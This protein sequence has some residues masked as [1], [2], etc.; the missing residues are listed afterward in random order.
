[1]DKIAPYRKPLKRAVRKKGN[2][3]LKQYKH[4]SQI[5]QAINEQSKDYEIGNLQEL[6]LMMGRTAR[7]NNRSIFRIESRTKSP[8][9]T[10]IFHWGG[11]WELQF[12]IRVLRSSPE[13]WIQT[14]LYGLAFSLES[15]RQDAVETLK[16]RIKMFNDYVKSHQRHF[17]SYRI[18]EA[19]GDIEKPIEVVNGIPDES[20]VEGNFIVMGKKESADN[21]VAKFI[22]SD[23]DNLLRVYKYVMR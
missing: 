18:H 16:P 14:V 8:D 17:A 15:N 11:R 22:L 23:F 20:I 2:L 5:A 3:M 9:R 10:Y 7:I 19:L 12:N 1:M 21:E 13:G 4:I 6:R